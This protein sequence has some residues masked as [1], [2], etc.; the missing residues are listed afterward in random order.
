[1]PSR[2]CRRSLGELG[3]FHRLIL[4]GLV[5]EGLVDVRDHTTTGD[6]GLDE[7]VELLV[8][9]DSELKVTWSDTL[10]LEVLGGVTRKLEHLSGEVLK[11]GSRVHG[12]SGTDAT[13][14]VNTLLEETVNTTDRELRGREVG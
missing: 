3:S 8:T 1:M 10:H 11:D 4:L 12:G 9:T 14:L 2:S 7:G 13:V 6:G 5:D